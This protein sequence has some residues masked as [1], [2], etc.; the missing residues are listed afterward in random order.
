M[1]PFPFCSRARKENL[2]LFLR[3]HQ[4]CFKRDHSHSRTIKCLMKYE[5]NSLIGNFFSGSLE[6]NNSITYINNKTVFSSAHHSPS[7]FTKQGTNLFLWSLLKSSFFSTFTILERKSW[8]VCVCPIVKAIPIDERIIIT[9]CVVREKRGLR[10][11]LS[12]QLSKKTVGHIFQN[13]NHRDLRP[14]FS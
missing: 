12:V 5:R 7:S 14:S 2:L 11:I 9:S 6:N 1:F 8:Q 13:R 4:D 3:Y 10:G